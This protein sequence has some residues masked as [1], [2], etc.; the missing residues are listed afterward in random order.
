MNDGPEEVG[1]ILATMIKYGEINNKHSNRTS[2]TGFE[3]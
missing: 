1:Q 3:I 2:G